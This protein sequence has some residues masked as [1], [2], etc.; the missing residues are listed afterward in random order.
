MVIIYSGCIGI[1]A[2]SV[3]DDNRGYHDNLYGDY[4]VSKNS[5]SPIPSTDRIELDPI[6]I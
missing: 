4:R 1:R 6:A 3:I 2:S 5:L